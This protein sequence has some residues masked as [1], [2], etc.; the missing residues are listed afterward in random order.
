VT[1][2]EVTVAKF[3][4]WIDGRATA[5]ASG[6]HLGSH[7]PADG[8]LVARIARGNA[9]DIGRAAEAARRAQPA[10][11][12]LSPGERSAALLRLAQAIR[13]HVDELGAL[14][15]AETGKLAVTLPFEIESSAAYFEYYAGIVRALSGELIDL[16]PSQHA[17]TR[18]E[19]FGVVG[20]ITPWNGP[21]N[22]GARG[23]APALA[24]GNTVVIKPSEFTSASTVTLARL[25]TEVAGL[26]DGV[27]NVVTGT[28]LEA[29]A[30]LIQHP[31]VGKVTFTGSVVTGKAV[32]RMAAERLI[33]TTL[34]LGGKSPHIIFADADR[35]RAAGVAVQ[36]FTANAGQVCSAGTRLLVERSVHDQVVDAVVRIVSA[37][38]PGQQIGAIITE[39]QYEKVQRYFDI[40]EQEGA[41][42][43]TGGAVASGIP[44]IENGWYVQP[45]VYT[46]VTN[47]MR[48]AREEIFGPV[49]CVIPF[50]GEEE[51]IAIDNDTPNGLVAGLHTSDVARAHRVAARIEAGQV[52][53]NQW[54][55]G[56]EMPFGGYKQS[57]HGREKGFEALMDYTRVKSVTVRL[58]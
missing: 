49:V 23:L 29:G 19:P 13:D 38:R 40:A 17:Y 27:L 15:G 39:P 8:R 33:P 3:D 26:P 52:F 11:G 36:A 57:G 46:G 7:G 48:I 45:T 4:H 25:A 41:H 30:A 14:E 44:E 53:V 20:V 16:G 22:Q 2:S 18:R 9:D 58:A 32:A 34:E 42:A 28:G 24:A 31:A 50:E 10:W 1:A 51:A 43:A 35:E 55:A 6:E 5:P 54:Q 56:M 12:A 47:D 21:L 37:M